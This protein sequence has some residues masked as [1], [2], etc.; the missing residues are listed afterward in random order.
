MDFTAIISD[1]A[2]LNPLILSGKVLAASGF[3]QLLLGIPLACWLARSRSTLS[4]IMD[5]VVTLPL[6][7]PPVAMG[8]G[9][10]LLLGRE[11]PMGALLGESIIFSFPGLVVAAFVAGLPL[12]V[13][14]IQA[15]L[16]SA[17]AA[18]LSEVAAV[19]GKSET[20][21]FLCVL[22]PYAKRSIAAGM[23]LALGRSLGEVGMTLML[24]GN[25]IGRT[26]T[27]SLEIYNAVFN[28]EF[29]RA[30]MLSLMIG[31]ASIAMFVVLKKV[32]DT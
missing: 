31:T 30:I 20:T 23:L 16:K 12:A 18:R 7:F 13:K 27:L 15:A 3:L 5:T 19:L 6:V 14:P 2:T 26:N 8:F 24:G 29:E 28:G 9:L 4:N 21:I 17:E 10:L 25:I 1:S 22:L 32:S 11:G